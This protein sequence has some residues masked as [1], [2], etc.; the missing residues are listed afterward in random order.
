MSS[1][2]E[3]LKQS[4]E[5]GF[6]TFKSILGD[7]FDSLT[8]RQKDSAQRCLK[9]LTKLKLKELQGEDVSEDLEFIQVTV[10]EF[11][12]AG[13]IALADA[14]NDAFWKGVNKASAAL[15]IFLVNV[16]KGLV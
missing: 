4:A 1:L 2:E 16:A 14:I 12:L 5:E 11:K 6:E 7:R 8:D 15:G 10:D 13:Q 9:R 3:G